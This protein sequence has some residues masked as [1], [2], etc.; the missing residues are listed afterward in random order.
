MTE[1]VASSTF[2]AWASGSALMGV[3]LPVAA[4]GMAVGGA[5]MLFSRSARAGAIPVEQGLMRREQQEGEEEEETGTE[6]VLWRQAKGRRSVDVER[7]EVLD[8]EELT[9]T[10]TYLESG[11]LSFSLAEIWAE[12]PPLGLHPFSP[13]FPRSLSVPSR[14]AGNPIFPPFPT[15]RSI[16]DMARGLRRIEHCAE[17]R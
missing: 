4:G 9:R 17:E 8:E 7:V 12:P 16:E 13:P 11:T 5:L 14:A 1:L 2:L 15:S 10:S 3:A 6:M